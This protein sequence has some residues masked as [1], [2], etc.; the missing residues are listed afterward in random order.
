MNEDLALPQYHTANA[1]QSRIS[2]TKRV[3]NETHGFESC[4]TVKHRDRS[5]YQCCRADVGFSLGSG[6]ASDE[7]EK[8]AL[9]E[10]GYPRVPS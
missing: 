6:S 10:C 2:E 4:G 9:E 3:S 8:E 1:G 7:R 5:S